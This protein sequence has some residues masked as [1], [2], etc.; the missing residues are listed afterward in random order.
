MKSIGE[1]CTTQFH[2]LMSHEAH[3]PMSDVT[4]HLGNCMQSLRVVVYHVSFTCGRME[5]YP[6]QMYIPL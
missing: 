6:C 4:L 5:L 1:S 3:V 2:C